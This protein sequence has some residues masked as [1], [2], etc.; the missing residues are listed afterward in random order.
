M[1]S[2]VVALEFSSLSEGTD[3]CVHCVFRRDHVV[4][5]EDTGKFLMGSHDSACAQ[6]TVA[7]LCPRKLLPQYLALGLALGPVMVMSSSCH[8]LCNPFIDHLVLAASPKHPLFLN[9]TIDGE[10]Q[11]FFP[12][13]CS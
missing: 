8:F 13:A 12:G 1:S 6:H 3:H 2:T 4:D 11:Y 7:V 10:I 5:Y 9:L